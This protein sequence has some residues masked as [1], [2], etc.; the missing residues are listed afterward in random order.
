MADEKKNPFNLKNA[1]FMTSGL[2]GLDPKQEKE[3]KTKE[4]RYPKISE[5]LMSDPFAY[6]VPKPKKGKK[7]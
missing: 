1:I 6:D 3:M 5:G 2:D 4:Q 7:K